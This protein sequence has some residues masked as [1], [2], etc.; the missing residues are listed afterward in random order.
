MFLGLDLYYICTD[1]AQHLITEDTG[2]VVD[3]LYDLYD[4][5]DLYRDLSK[6]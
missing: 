4:P 3:D 1:H 2:P 5:L 6:V